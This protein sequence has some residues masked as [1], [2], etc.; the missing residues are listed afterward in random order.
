MD[1]K[2]FALKLKDIFLNAR[3]ISNFKI[4]EGIKGMIPVLKI[5]CDSDKEIT[6]KDIEDELSITSARTARVLNQLQEKNY[7]KRIKSEND[8]RKTIV[9]LTEEGKKISLMHREMFY[10]NIDI[11]LKDITDSEKEMFLKL[12]EKM[13]NNLKERN[14]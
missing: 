4:E 7:I 3:G 12:M 13:V 11:M 10:K 2:E 6:P 9:V 8:K 5:L 14:D 1:N